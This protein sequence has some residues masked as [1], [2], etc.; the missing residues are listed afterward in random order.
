MRTVGQILKETRETKFYSLDEVEKVIKIRKELLAALEA[1][2]YS[3]LP[4][5]TFVQGFIKNYAKFLGLDREKLLAIFRREFSEKRFKPQVM[6]AFSN[7]SPDTRL[8]FTPGRVIGTVV[9]TVVMIFFV[10]LWFQYRQFVNPPGLLVYAPADQMTTDNPILTVE[11]KTDPEG[12]VTVNGQEISVS[13][14]GDFK[15]EITLSAPINKL[16]IVVAARFGRKSQIER[17]IYLKR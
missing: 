14:T 17:T 16:T 15:E 3:N 2:D 4:P 7:Q 12:K 1:D 11:G 6:E 9:V 8:K 5:S 13:G 10:Y